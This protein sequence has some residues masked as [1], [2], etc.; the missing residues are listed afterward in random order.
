MVLQLVGITLFA[1][2]TATITSRFVLRDEVPSDRL[3]DTL[4]EV[5]ALHADGVLTDAE[6]AAKKTELL[7]RI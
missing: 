3:G 5:A 2:V 7:A 6:Y 1:A 4:R